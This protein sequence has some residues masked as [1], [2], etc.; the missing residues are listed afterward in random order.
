MPTIQT[1]AIM[2]LVELSSGQGLLAT[3]HLRLAVENLLTR[4]SAEQTSEA[5]GVT[6]WGILT[7]HTCI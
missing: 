1:C 6:F 5:E 2:F 4:K 7:L 3:S